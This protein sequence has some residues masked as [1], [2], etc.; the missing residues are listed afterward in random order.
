MWEQVA[1]FVKA[2]VKFEALVR[3]RPGGQYVQRGG[4]G[5]PAYRGIYSVHTGRLGS[6]SGLRSPSLAAVCTVPF[7][8]YKDSFCDMEPYLL[9]E[10]IVF[11]SDSFT[12]WEPASW[13]NR[14]TGPRVVRKLL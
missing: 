12:F 2:Y 8:Q 4:Q 13:F 11:L 1:Y 9:R 10:K 7:L 14:V 3:E 6:G 5:F